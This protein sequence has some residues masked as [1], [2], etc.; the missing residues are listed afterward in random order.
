M[1]PAHYFEI[2]CCPGCRGEL[3]QPAEDRLRCGGC[4]AEYAV[5][6]GVPVLLAALDDEVSRSIAGFYAGVWKVWQ[7]PALRITPDLAH[8][9]VSPYGQRYTRAT[10]R[11][12]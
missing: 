1:L 8:D 10:E 12:F 11:R 6:A 4:A 5:V 2:L 3:A 9:D 7:E